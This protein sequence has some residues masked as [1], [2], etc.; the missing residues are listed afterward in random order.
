MQNQSPPLPFTDSDED[1]FA[2]EGINSNVEKSTSNQEEI[3]GFPNGTCKALLFG[4][5]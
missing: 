1:G 5:M 4:Q 3:A 2:F